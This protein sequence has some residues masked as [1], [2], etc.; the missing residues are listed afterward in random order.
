MKYE[1]KYCPMGGEWYYMIYRKILC[2]SVFYERWNT[3]EKAV[4]RIKE[5]RDE[6]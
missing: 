6:S 3:A 5:L 1:I 4:K 2:F